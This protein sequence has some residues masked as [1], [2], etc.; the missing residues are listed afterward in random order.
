MRNG[1]R[2]IRHHVAKKFRRDILH[3]RRKGDSGREFIQMVCARFYREQ[4]DVLVLGECTDAGYIRIRPMVIDAALRDKSCILPQTR[5]FLCSGTT[6]RVFREFSSSSS[7]RY[8]SHFVHLKVSQTLSWWHQTRLCGPIIQSYRG[9]WQRW[10]IV[11]DARLGG[12]IWT[13]SLQVD[14]KVEHFERN[15]ERDDGKSCIEYRSSRE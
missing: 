14:R 9:K 10:S 3:L 11:T 5:C 6:R 13:N 15:G 1:W 12:T 7:E 2:Y 4:R 8:L